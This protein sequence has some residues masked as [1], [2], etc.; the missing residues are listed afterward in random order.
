MVNLYLFTIF[1]QSILMAVE[2]DMELRS[3]L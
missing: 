1:K 2:R 3:R